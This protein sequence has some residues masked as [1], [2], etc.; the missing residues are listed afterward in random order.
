MLTRRS[1]LLGLM[2][3]DLY[4]AKAAEQRAACNRR[5]LPP[6]KSGN[7][8]PLSGQPLPALALLVA[9]QPWYRDSSVDRDQSIPADDKHYDD[10]PPRRSQPRRDGAATGSGVPAGQAATRAGLAKAER[11]PSLQPSSSLS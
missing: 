4:S 2:L 7:R 8:S 1:R 9:R 10:Q 3:R 6:T 11:C 5:Q